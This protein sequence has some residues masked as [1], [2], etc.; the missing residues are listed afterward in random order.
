MLKQSGRHW[1]IGL[2]I[3]IATMSLVA[4]PGN[5]TDNRSSKVALYAGVGDELIGYSVDV[6]RGA[7][8]RRSPVT[9]PGFVQEAWVSPSTPFLYVAWSNGGTSYIGSGVAPLG[10]RHGVT[11][12]RVDS[13]GALHLQGAPAS[14]RS[15]PIHI[16]GDVPGRHLLVA[17]NDPSGI[18]VHAINVDGSVGA[19]VPQANG[20]DVGIYAHQVRVLSSNRAVI[21]VTRGNQPTATTPEDPGAVKVFRYDD[22]RLTNRASIAP[23]KGI[24]FRSR[25]LDVHPTRPWVF[26]TLESQNRL[27]V[28]T[29]TN[30]DSLSEQP[31]F[32]KSTL[33]AS[34]SVSAGQTASSVHVDRTG[35]FVYVGNRAGGTTDFN[36]TPVSAG[37]SNDIAVFRINQETGEPSLIQNIDTRGFTPRTFA[38]D[39]SGRMLV[40]GNQ[41][42]MA[43]RN[44]T[45]VKTVPANLAVFKIRPDGR[46]DF[47]KQYD[48]AVGRKPLWWMGVVAL[49]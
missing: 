33:S 19:E 10:T 5:Q 34:G 24:G 39:P 20:L 17:Y 6:E 12:F 13:S 43:V 23:G 47:V 32:S 18:S 14:L 46:L 27:D 29:R 42:T 22:G 40:V 1:R 31:L 37:G 15:R 7:L 45:T 4:A 28:F 30:D 11:A 25:H 16:S 38:L 41:T 36:G 35:Q 2:W 44:G 48:V 21:L 26:L 8:T 3:A 9:L 49:Q